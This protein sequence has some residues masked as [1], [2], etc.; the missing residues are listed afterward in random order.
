[1]HSQ[2]LLF[3]TIM[4]IMRIAMLRYNGLQVNEIGNITSLVSFLID[5]D[6]TTFQKGNDATKK[7]SSGR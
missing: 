1:M 7:N 4:R 2:Y 5:P 3:F 6:A